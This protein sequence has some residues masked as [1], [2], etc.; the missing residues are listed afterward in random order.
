ML[1]KHLGAAPQLARPAQ[2]PTTFRRATL[3]HQLIDAGASFRLVGSIGAIHSATVC[4]NTLG[5]LCTI[6]QRRS[7]MPAML[8]VL[9]SSVRKN[10]D[11][12]AKMTMPRICTVD[13]LSQSGRRMRA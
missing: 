6:A 11:A 4:W 12:Y 10:Y 5:A 3:F 2:Q 13:T 7:G 1:L 9:P 8:P